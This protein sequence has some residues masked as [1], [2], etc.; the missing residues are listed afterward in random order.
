MTYIYFVLNFRPVRD[1]ENHKTNYF[2][3]HQQNFP[4]SEQ[5][6]DYIELLFDLLNEMTQFYTLN[7]KET[8]NATQWYYDTDQAQAHFWE[9]GDA[10]KCKHYF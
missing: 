8:E 3:G 9:E 4:I 7:P 10:R 5:F 2:A 6:T 1:E